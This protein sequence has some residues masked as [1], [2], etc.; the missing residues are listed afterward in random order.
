M[1]QISLRPIVARLA[2]TCLD[3]TFHD[4]PKFNTSPGLD[5]SLNKD[6]VTCTPLNVFESDKLSQ[7]RHALVVWLRAD[8]GEGDRRER[9]WT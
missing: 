6:T 7:V 4:V 9:L 2:T 8:S 5:I 1:S 3:F